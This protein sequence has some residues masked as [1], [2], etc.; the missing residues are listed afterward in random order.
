MRIVIKFLSGFFCLDRE[1]LMTDV[2]H[3]ILCFL[4]SNKFQLTV[5]KRHSMHP[6]LNNIT[7]GTYRIDAGLNLNQF[8]SRVRSIE[9]KKKY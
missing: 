1:C 9:H 4:F 2:L 5:P 7:K 8:N 3:Y 6:A